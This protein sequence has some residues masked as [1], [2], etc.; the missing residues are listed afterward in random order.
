MSR[1]APLLPVYDFSA[2]PESISLRQ[3]C[4]EVTLGN[5][6]LDGTA[7]LM[8][9]FLP[10]PRLI[11]RA[12][13][14]EDSGSR[15]PN[16]FNEDN[17]PSFSFDGQSVE[18]F[19]GR[20]IPNTDTLEFDW[21]SKAEQ[22]EFYDMKPKTS[23]ASILHIFNFPNF[24]GGEHQHTAPAGCCLMVLESDEW[25]FSVQALPNG[26]TGQ[27]WKK[28]KE[29]G[30]CFLT[31]VVKLERKDGKHFSGQ[32]AREQILL[33]T[34]FLSFVQ[35]SNRSLG[36]GVGFNAEGAKT[37]EIFTAPRFSNPPHSWFTTHRASQAEL[38]FPLFA[39][40]WRQSPE[41]R[42]CLLS[43][44]YWYVQA[45]TDGRS[46]SINAGIIL[47]QAALERLAYHHLVV[48]K[49]MISEDRF[50]KLWVSDRLRLLFSSLNIP[51][52]IDSSTPKI[53]NVA[54]KWKWKDGPHAITDIRNELVHPVSRKQIGDCFF[55][56]WKL[57]LWYLELSVLA[58]C[59]YSDTYTNR[60]TASHVTYSEYVPWEGNNA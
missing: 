52:A 54:S 35:G 51:I 23:V 20:F 22:I 47:A 40:R 43:V 38:L 56:A 55:D 37:W 13:V 32:D 34:T 44:V 16:F 48:N 17:D 7:Q 46:S 26:G 28:I 30:G 57:N 24:S 25:H 33:L 5:D 14:S 60:L 58:L 6:S 41:W 19:Y 2:A 9:R 1:P 50:D 11:F 31:H 42:Q 15:N 18:G 45:N 10:N 53:E 36:C 4:A 8:L 27:A 3:G 29:D 49:Q 59:G 39:K 12:S 21:I